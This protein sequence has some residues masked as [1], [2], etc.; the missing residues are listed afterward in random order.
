[1]NAY[2]SKLTFL[3][4]LLIAACTPKDPAGNAERIDRL[5]RSLVD[6][7]QTAGIAFQL[8]VDTLLSRSKT[9]G[10]SDLEE[11]KQIR[12]DA[13][14]RIAS[15]TKPITATAVFQLIESGRLSLEDRLN[16]FFPDFPNGEKI[17]I[18]QLLA[19]TSGI[20]NWWEGGMPE[21]EPADFPMCRN[22]HRYLERMERPSLFEPGTFHYYSNSGYVLLGE[23]IELV[24]GLPYETYL[25]KHIFPIAGMKHTEMEYIGHPR[26][27]WVTGYVKREDEQ[28]PFSDP[29]VYHMPFSAGGL[30]STA[31]DLLL[32]INALE[33]G[34]LVSEA[35]FRQM[36]SYARLN[37]GAFV[38][39]NLFSPTG[40]T[41]RF[42]ENIRKFG[43]GLGFQIVE[44]FGSKVV[45][46]GGDISGFNSLIMMVPH[47]GVKMAILSN[48]ENGILSRLKKIEKLAISIDP[49]G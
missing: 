33:K 26:K 14:F 36:T 39:E 31:G 21:D 34:R 32:F 10:F 12:P 37:S 46:H 2:F 11:Q 30:R 16:G 18:Y 9:Y 3:L 7:E 20:P 24:S 38:Y 45:F 17:T 5:I 43:Y 19:H 35:S 41:I 47:N 29:Q 40:E 23:I 48:T 15:V 6:E 28:E 13:P 22:P 8:E 49:N 44:N 1:M 4:L 25:E 42:P 27:D